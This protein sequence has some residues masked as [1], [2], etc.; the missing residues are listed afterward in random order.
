MLKLHK[1]DLIFSIKHVTPTHGNFSLLS[2]KSVRLQG[3][4][5]PVFGDKPW[6]HFICYVASFSEIREKR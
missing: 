2:P 6:N 5:Q 3:R 1:I 4:S